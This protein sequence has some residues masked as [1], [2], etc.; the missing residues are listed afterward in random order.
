MNEKEKIEEKRQKSDKEQALVHGLPSLVDIRVIRQIHRRIQPLFVE[1]FQ[2][3][4]QE[5][6]N[7]FPHYHLDGIDDI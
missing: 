6:V 2:Q 1:K 7:H 3:A 4:D 5:K